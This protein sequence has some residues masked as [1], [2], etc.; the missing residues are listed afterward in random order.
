MIAVGC[1]VFDSQ[2]AVNF[3]NE[4]KGV[5]ASI[6]AH[7][8]DGQDFIDDKE[9]AVE[10]LRDLAKGPKVVAIGEIGL[11]FYRDFTPKNDQE[12]ILRQQLQLGQELGLPFV[13]H[14]REAWDAFWPIFD[15][16][17]G[18]RGVIHSISATPAQLENA[19]ARGLMVGLNG[20]LTYTKEE[21][22]RE[23][24]KLAPLNRIILETDAP[25]LTPIPERGRR[26]EPRHVAVTAKFLADLRQEELSRFAAATTANCIELFSLTEERLGSA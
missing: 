3:A 16:Y 15:E 20:L 5:W 22:W 11:D 7:P 4:H 1:S 19:L 13:F 14:V 24:A 26:C 23:S 6:G 17:P 10:K 18:I 2:R 8:N 12:N 21:S 25:F 9:S